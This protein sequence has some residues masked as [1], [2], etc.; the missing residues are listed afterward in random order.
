MLMHVAML[1]ISVSRFQS[2]SCVRSMSATPFSVSAS[3]VMPSACA[4]AKTAG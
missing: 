1:A 4:T 2:S 3:I